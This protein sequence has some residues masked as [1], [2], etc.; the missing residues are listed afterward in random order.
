MRLNFGEVRAAFGEVHATDRVVQGVAVTPRKQELGFRLV[1]ISLPLSEV[2]PAFK[3]V[4]RNGSSDIGDHSLY[5]RAIYDRTFSPH[6]R[7][8]R[9]Q[10]DADLVGFKAEGFGLCCCS[11]KAR[12]PSFRAT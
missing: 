11:A 10:A 1:R 8:L 6:P 9:H 7:R 2:D 5:C 4:M 12:A 3:S